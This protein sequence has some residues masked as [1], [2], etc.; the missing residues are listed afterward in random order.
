V[1]V[2]TQT[3]RVSVCVFGGGDAGG[4]FVQFCGR[5]CTCVCVFV[6]HSYVRKQG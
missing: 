4:L 3:Q 6:I 2:Y 5:V 1:R